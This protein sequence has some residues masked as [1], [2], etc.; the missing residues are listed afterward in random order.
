MNTSKNYTEEQVELLTTLYN[1]LG[2]EH[3]LEI[4]EKLGKP[5]NSVRAKLVKEKVYIAP[6]KPASV[7]KN[8][9]SKKELLRELEQLGATEEQVQG[10]QSATKSGLLFVKELMEK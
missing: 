2:N 6:E 4:A 5:I 3:L 7:R 10:L 9:P 1:E 8:G